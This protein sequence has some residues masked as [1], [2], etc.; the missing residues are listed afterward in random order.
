LARARTPGLRIVIIGP[1]R[2]VRGGPTPQVLENAGV[3]VA[4]AHIAQVGAL[5]PLLAAYP[6]ENVWEGGGRVMMPGL[7]DAHAHLARHLARGLGLEREAD[8]EC[9]DR[10]LAPEDVLWGTMAALTEALRHGITTVYDV[11]RSASCLDLSLSE[12]ANAAQ[13]TGVR[14]ATCYAV[15]ERDT[16]AERAAALVE[17]ASLALDL[18]RRRSGRLQA[19]TGVRAHTMRGLEGLL[20]EVASSTS[21]SPLHIELASAPRHGERWSARVP[22]AAPCLWSHAEHA[23]LALVSEARERGDALAWAQPGAWDQGADPDLAWGSDDGLHAPPR[24]PETS[25][26]GAWRQAEVYYQRAWVAGPR[27]AARHFGEGLGTIEP[28]APAD[29]VLLDYQPPTELDAHTLPAHAAAGLA[30]APVAGVMVAGEV[31]MD[32]GALRTVD[33]AE[34]AARAREC[35]RRLWR[36]LA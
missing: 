32:G 21:E 30:R 18:R 16:P 5:A 10:T 31:L 28:G 7:V 29:L 9:Y 15:D 12:L 36:R 27:W 17:S 22:R 6:D 3:R 13:R 20:D 8:W 4:G 35:A 1:C 23:P 26:T 24:P 19:M 25:V 2:V 33:E 14:L 34:I 11:H